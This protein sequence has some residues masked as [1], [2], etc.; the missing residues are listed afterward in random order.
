[1]RIHSSKK[2]RGH[3]EQFSEL[4]LYTAWRDEKN[5]HE[6][7]DDQC[8]LEFANRIDE[9]KRNKEMIYPG[10]GT[11]E[12][13]E[14]CDLEAN[15]PEH[16]Y[17]MLDSQRQQEK[18]DDQQIGTI[19]DPEFESFGYTGNLGQER[20]Y[21]TSKYR[22][23]EL[24]S[25]DE[26]KYLTRRLVPEQLNILREFVQYSKDVVKNQKNPIHKVKPIR[27]MVHGGAGNIVWTFMSWE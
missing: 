13:L 12:L 6:G 22:K 23:I 25:N 9:I 26:L 16:I 8:L 27:A 10:E 2:K 20:T 14:N 3:E 7:D 19:D 1:M 24:P 4:Q 5:F 18:E 11:T 21:E 15:R 17:D